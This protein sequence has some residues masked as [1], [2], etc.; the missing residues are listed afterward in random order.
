MVPMM[1]MSMMNKSK[2]NNSDS[3]SI[4]LME[5]LKKQNEIMLAM[6]GG[7]MAGDSRD[8]ENNILVNKLNELEEKLA[9]KMAKSNQG[10]GGM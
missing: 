10:G 4:A 7:G 2:K 3:S 5:S 8:G 9:S 6:E 1:M